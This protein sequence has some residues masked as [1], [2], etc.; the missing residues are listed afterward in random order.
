MG[1]QE[2]QAETDLGFDNREHP[3]GFKLFIIV[4]DL[5]HK[6]GFLLITTV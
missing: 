4:S 1:R 6:N 2:Q 3:F 5:N